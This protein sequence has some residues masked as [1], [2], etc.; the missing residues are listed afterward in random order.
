MH[1]DIPTLI[2]NIKVSNYTPLPIDPKIRMGKLANGL[3]YYIIPNQYPKNRAAFK[4]VRKVGA[5]VERP[6]EWGLAHFLEHMAFKGT[7][8]FPGKSIINYLQKKGIKWGSNFNAST[9]YDWTQFEINHVD[10]TD[11]EL[12]ENILLILRDWS[13]SLLLNPEDIESERGVI[14]EELLSRSD[15]ITRM[16]QNVLP[17][18]YK[19]SCYQHLTIGTEKTVM[20]IT[21]DM[22]KD[23][24]KK[25]YRP[26]LQA[27]VIAGDFDAEQMQK[28]I[29][30]LFSDICMPENPRER[31]Y[32]KITQNQNPVYVDYMDKETEHPLIFLQFKRDAIPYSHRSSMEYFF[33]EN[34]VNKLISNMINSRFQDRL[35]REDCSYTLAQVKYGNYIISST[36]KAFITVIYTKGDAIAATKDV[37][38][39]LARV[40]Q[41]GFGPKE[42]ARAKDRMIAY[43]ERQ[44]RNRDKIDNAEL[45]TEASKHFLDNTPLLDTET[46]YDLIKEILLHL[47]LDFLNKAF[48]NLLVEENMTVVTCLPDSQGTDKVSEEKMLEVISNALASDYPE[49]EESEEDERPATNLLPPGYIISKQYYK[50][51]IISYL[52]SNGIK[53]IVQLTTFKENEILFT[54]KKRGGYSSYPE[55]EASNVKLM[56]FAFFTLKSGNQDLVAQKRYYNGK[57]VNLKFSM[58]YHS[59]L[60]E[61]ASTAKDFPWLLE[62]IYNIFTNIQPDFGTYSKTMDRARNIMMEDMKDPKNQA[63]LQEELIVY[64]GNP[65]QTDL[66]SSEIETGNY[67][68]I[69][70]F[71]SDE[72]HNAAAYTF[73]FTG[74]IK[75]DEEFQNLLCKYLASIPAYK[76]IEPQIITPWRFSHGPIDMSLQIKMVE[77]R[78]FITD[79]YYGYEMKFCNKNLTMLMMVQDLLSHQ[80]LTSIREDLGSTYSPEV[81]CKY[82]LIQKNWQLSCSLETSRENIQKVKERETALMK[83]IFM[84]GVDR[85]I[86]SEI[87]EIVKNSFSKFKDTNSGREKLLLRHL[88]LAESEEP[89]DSDY[90]KDYEDTLNSITLEDFNSFIRGLY[91]ENRHLLIVTE[92]QFG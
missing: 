31:I 4:L 45:V 76:A 56:E 2:N 57:Q 21:P 83:N 17:K 48:R 64:A 20:S 67:D 49:F 50:N 24:Y 32:Q 51:G 8:H 12:I 79:F 47:P 59:T 69:Y 19:E 23:F 90:I 80:L 88:A 13:D 41:K 92:G 61:A 65:Y 87:L 11:S 42:F 28:R 84:N 55:S 66:Q 74:D 35:L 29:V 86:F 58:K 60:L 16:W 54:A 34:V 27:L 52:L 53:V 63:M 3:T 22:M 25:W 70:Q 15:F 18:I 46:K 71:L 81:E 75:D 43:Y 77:P 39:L 10:T 68:Q 5:V 40:Q 72:L 38:E 85:S 6:E 14:H 1:I 7:R 30:S 33:L 73:F 82:D 62:R 91:N 9:T 78:A 44:F 36:Q 37:M 26:D 89:S